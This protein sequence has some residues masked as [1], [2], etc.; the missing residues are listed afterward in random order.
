MLDRFTKIF[1]IKNKWLWWYNCIRNLR[2]GVKAMFFIGVFGIEQKEKEVCILENVECKGCK[3][4]LT[5]VKSYSFFHFFF[6]PLF[7]WNIRYYALCKSC[8]AV[9]EIS[10]DKGQEAEEGRRGTI[11]YWDLKEASFSY[12]HH[13]ICSSC[14]RQVQGDFD[15]CPYCGSKLR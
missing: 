13:R 8:G 10:K 9:Y 15:Y 6:I 12:N 2:R 3:P 5:L 11:S 7:K 14:H 4:V 1:I